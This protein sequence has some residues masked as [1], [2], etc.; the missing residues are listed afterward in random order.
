MRRLSWAPGM[1]GM[2]ITTSPTEGCTLP[3]CFFLS[4][5]SIGVM[6][7]QKLIHLSKKGSVSVALHWQ[8]A[9]AVLVGRHILLWSFFFFPGKCMNCCFL[10]HSKAISS[11]MFLL[12]GGVEGNCLSPSGI[13]QLL[14]TWESNKIDCF[15]TEQKSLDWTSKQKVMLAKPLSNPYRRGPLG[16]S[17][18][19]AWGTPF[20]HQHFV[21]LKWK[22]GL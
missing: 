10:C 7:Q 20:T 11:V 9:A 12:Y 8:P 2:E 22:R 4:F 17:L 1:P 18:V 21:L 19:S 14:F 16:T 3:W 15:W 5:P 13:M 6:V